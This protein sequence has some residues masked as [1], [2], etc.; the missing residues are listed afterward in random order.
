M[1]YRIITTVVTPASS[2]RL[3]SLDDVKAELGIT[4]ATQ[5]ALLGRLIDVCSAAAAQFCDRVF[6]LETVKDEV[7]PDREPHGCQV[8]PGIHVLQ[9]SRWPVGTVASV[10][11]NGDPLTDGV[12][13]RVDPVVGQV[14]RFDASG[15]P[16]PWRA[17]PLAVEYE[18]GYAAVPLDVQDA[19]IR[20]VRARYFAKGR[21]PYLRSESIEGVRSASWW[22]PTGTDAAA[23]PPDV[24][25]ILSNYRQPQVR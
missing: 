13:Y 16:C 24:A 18:A 11:E 9:L 23:M 14:H 7:W 25:D 10:T 19:V 4:D 8:L 12:G 6:P 15:Y 17:W 20:L 22:V 1:G 21:D 3:A 5:D 2:Q